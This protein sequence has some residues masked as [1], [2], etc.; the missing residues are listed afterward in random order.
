MVPGISFPPKTCIIL[1]CPFFMTLTISKLLSSLR[2][3]NFYNMVFPNKKL[4][5]FL[6]LIL[7]KECKDFHQAKDGD[8]WVE[9]SSQPFFFGLLQK[10]CTVHLSLHADSF[11]FCYFFDLT[12]N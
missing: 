5:L 4:I 9:Q 1:T 2:D 6:E 12:Y 7:S 8:G 11:L 10:V 3:P